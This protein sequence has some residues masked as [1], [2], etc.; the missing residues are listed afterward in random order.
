MPAPETAPIDRVTLAS[1]TYRVS[2]PKSVER[3]FKGRKSGP[4]MTRVEPG[5]ALSTAAK[6]PYENVA[7]ITANVVFLI[8]MMQSC[9][10]YLYK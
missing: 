2:G 9:M 1:F 8:T 10:Q 4:L 3:D 7:A 5:A 6:A